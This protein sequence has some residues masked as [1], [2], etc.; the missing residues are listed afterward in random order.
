MQ[1]TLIIVDMLGWSSSPPLQLI[2]STGYAYRQI[3]NSKLAWTKLLSEINA[4]ET[5]AV[6]SKK[7]VIMLISE[8]TT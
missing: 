4:P 1:I 7:I 5:V 6:I 3:V 8:A 2:I